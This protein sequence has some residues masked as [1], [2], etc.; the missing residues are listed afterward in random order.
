MAGLT[1]YAP[2]VLIQGLS[3]R[4]IVEPFILDVMTHVN[5]LTFDAAHAHHKT[6]DLDGLELH[7]IHRNDLVLNKRSSG[8]GKGP[9]NVRSLQLIEVYWNGQKLEVYAEP[10]PQS[11]PSSDSGEPE[12]AAAE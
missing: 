1:E 7:L 4:I 6:Y 2:Q 12:A 3:L 5:G 11:S 10:A 8:R 9:A